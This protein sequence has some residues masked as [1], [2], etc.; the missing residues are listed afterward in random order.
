MRKGTRALLILCAEGVSSSIL[1]RSVADQ[2]QCDSASIPGTIEEEMAKRRHLGE[3]L[4]QT[5][6][7]QEGTD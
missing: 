7:D 1:R 3:I 4:D 2:Q 5:Q 6:E